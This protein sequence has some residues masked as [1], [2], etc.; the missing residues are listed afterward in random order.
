L[1]GCEKL[2]TEEYIPTE[3]I[4]LETNLSVRIADGIDDFN[5]NSSNVAQTISVILVTVGYLTLLVSFKQ[6]LAH[7]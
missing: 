7:R 1:N 6:C 2:Q 4:L 3:T 5:H